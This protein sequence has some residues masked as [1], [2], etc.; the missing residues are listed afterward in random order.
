MSNSKIKVVQDMT[1]IIQI[2]L[3]ALS[4]RGIRSKAWPRLFQIGYPVGCG[5]PRVAADAAIS[6]VL[7]PGIMSIPEELKNNPKKN[8]NRRQEPANLSKPSIDAQFSTENDVG[9]VN[10]RVLRLDR[11]LF[12][13]LTLAIK[14]GIAD[15]SGGVNGRQATS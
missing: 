7:A 14:F 13:L 15:F 8:R 6:P 1:I 10:I 5:I 3:L 11:L 2:G 12:S 9:E 4:P